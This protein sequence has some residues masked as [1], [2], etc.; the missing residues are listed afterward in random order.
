MDPREL[1][2]PDAG[3]SLGRSRARVP[4]VLRAAGSPLGVQ[5]VADRTG[6]HPNTERFH[7]DALAEAGLATRHRPA[8]GKPPR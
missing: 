6:L 4:E 7:L 8:A 3:A 1:L 5:E 2:A